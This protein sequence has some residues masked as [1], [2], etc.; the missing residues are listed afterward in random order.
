MVQDYY[1]AKIDIPL[2]IYFGFSNADIG[3][4]GSIDPLCEPIRYPSLYFFRRKKQNNTRNKKGNYSS[5]NNG[6]F[7]VFFD[8]K[9]V[10]LRLHKG[11]KWQHKNHAIF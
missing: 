4:I 1:V 11:I 10:F 6:Y 5:E 9:A 8:E 2:K 3:R 7:T